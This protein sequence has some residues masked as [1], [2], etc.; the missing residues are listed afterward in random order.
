MKSP[1][2]KFTLTLVYN[3]LIPSLIAFVV[4]IAMSDGNWAK[5]ANPAAGVFYLI[6]AVNVYCVAWRAGERDRNLVKFG[7]L[8]YK[9]LRGLWAGLL[10]VIPFVALCAAVIRVG[11][12]MWFAS[13]FAVAPLC[14]MAGYLLGYRLLRIIDK[15]IYRGKPRK[16]HTRRRR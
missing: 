13:V 10:S 8:T 14:S 9:P 12:L 4:Y 7:H 2:W 3:I 5:W 6:T 11:G 15:V 16:R 1:L